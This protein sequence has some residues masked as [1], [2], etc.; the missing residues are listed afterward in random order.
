DHAGEEARFGEPE[1]KT[2]GE[3]ADR[4]AN[5]R[6][7][8]RNQA[9][10][11]HYAGNPAPRADPVEDQIARHLQYEIAPEERTGSKPENIR[12]QSEILVH[13]QRGEADVHAVEITYEQ[14]RTL[15][16]PLRNALKG[17]NWVFSPGIPPNSGSTRRQCGA[18][19]DQV[20]SCLTRNG[21]WR[22]Q[23]CLRSTCIR[24]PTSQLDR[25]FPCKSTPL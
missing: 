23:A 4:S 24:F 10:G 25:L 22:R 3:K 1:E 20:R 21:S 12:A 16:H 11:H 2:Q 13:R 9:P 8:A 17:G 18:A 15:L 7:P 5:E 14:F 19:T 6:K